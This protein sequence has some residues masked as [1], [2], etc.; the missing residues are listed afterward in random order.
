MKGLRRKV[1]FWLI[2][3]KVAFSFFEQCEM[4][5]QKNI[6]LSR[7]NQFIGSADNE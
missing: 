2:L 4:D 1:V 6:L 3:N 7:R 5:S